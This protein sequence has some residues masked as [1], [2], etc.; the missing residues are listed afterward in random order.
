MRIAPDASV[1]D[2]LFDVCILKKTGLIEFLRAFPNVY[3][4]THVTHPKVMML[5]GSQVEV[6]CVPAMPLLIDG[7]MEGTTPVVF[8]VQPAALRA[9]IH[10]SDFQNTT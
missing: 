9:A 3:K 6:I 7:E 10:E 5:K 4:G 8:T 2:G 1:Q